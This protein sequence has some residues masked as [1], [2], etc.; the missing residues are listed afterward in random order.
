MIQVVSIVRTAANEWHIKIDDEIMKYT[1]IS[2]TS[3]TSIT[4]AQGGTTAATHANGATVE[5][6]QLHKVPLTEVN[7][8][9]TAI[10]NIGIDDYTVLLSTS[11]V[12]AGSGVAEN[13]GSAV[14]ATEN[15]QYDVAQPTVSTLEP[16]G[17]S[18]SSMIRPTTGVSPSG[19]QTPFSLTSLANAI[20]SP[21]G[22][23][24]E[25][26]VPQL[27]ASQIN[28]TNEM[29]GSKS[30]VL[31]VN[32]NSSHQNLSPVIDTKRAS[33]FCISNRIN[34]IDSSSDVYPTTDLFGIN[35][36]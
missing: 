32:L 23:N 29:G 16:A 7:K 31:D 26:A 15:V 1:G 30:L 33:L 34:N 11:P 17:T 6:Y 20:V 8:T 21:L 2:G 4:R 12:I 9:F 13:G 5:L 28:E 36:T 35:G 27:V 25:Y 10:A 14:T 18:V 24:Y 19:S 22:E 3:V